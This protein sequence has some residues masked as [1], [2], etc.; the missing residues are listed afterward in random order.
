MEI[1]I[2]SHEY[3]YGDVYDKYK[4]NEESRF[5]GA[6]YTKKDAL[7]ALLKYQRIRGFS[8]HLDGFWIV[9]HEVD[10]NLGWEDG[11]VT[12]CV[13]N[14][15][16]NG[17]KIDSSKSRKL[18]VLSHFYYTDSEKIQE[19]HRIL[20]VCLSKLEAKNKIK[21]YRK[22]EGFSSHISNFYIE[23][24]VLDEIKK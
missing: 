14:H 22:I 21:E 15:K 20:S 9:K 3:E 8:S 11:Y 2:L 4:W 10:K 6:Y 16:D 23:E 5:L 12:G 17:I 19:K 24:Y 7:K 1:W 13:T 18:Y